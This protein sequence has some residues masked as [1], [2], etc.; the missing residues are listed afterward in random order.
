[1][2]S[3]RVKSKTNAVTSIS[4]VGCEGILNFETLPNLREK[5]L[6]V[7][8]DFRLPIATPPHTK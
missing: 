2:Q 1:M 3:I 4:H 5:I 7:I 8:A 6:I